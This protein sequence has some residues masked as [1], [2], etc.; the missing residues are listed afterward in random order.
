MK[1]LQ[2]FKS[3]FVPHEHNNFE[4]HS[5]RSKVLLVVALC[6]VVLEISLFVGTLYVYR[7]T[8]YLAAVVP[9]SL[10]V[11]TNGVR[12][13]QH[14]SPLSTNELLTKAAVLKAE[15]MANRGYFSHVTPEGREPWYFLD[16]VSYPYT[17]A[18][19]N[20][21]VNFIDS[22][23]VV[24][25]WIASPSHRENLLSQNYTDVG[26]GTAVGMYK[27]RKATFVVQY[28]ATPEIRSAPFAKSVDGNSEDVVAHAT[29]QSGVVAGAAIAP[30]AQAEHLS[31]FETVLG[32][33]RS[34]L[35]V[36]YVSVLVVALIALALSVFIK[37]HI[38]S[39]A[40]VVKAS[41]LISL[42]IVFIF[43]NL[44][45]FKKSI[46]IPQDSLSASIISVL[47]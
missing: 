24:S 18:G 30:T 40:S 36:V 29:P 20:L 19:E 28:F 17:F 32:S 46:I 42:L 35:Q 22:S 26:V 34:A 23:D 43:G 10:I 8:K 38:Q 9:R 1:F 14:I 41:A 16:K 4:P 2:H 13:Q 33:P 5:M 47:R 37:I 7:S 27:G 31:F 44:Y 21:A 12:Q 3:F 25:A 15:D 39:L 11:L 45:L 6:V